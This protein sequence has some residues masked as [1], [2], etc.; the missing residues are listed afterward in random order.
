MFK[1]IAISLMCLLAICSASLADDDNDEQKKNNV[2]FIYN[3]MDIGGGA[4]ESGHYFT[5]PSGKIYLFPYWAQTPI[6]TPTPKPTPLPTPTPKPTPT[7][8]PT[9]A[10]TKANAFNSCMQCHK[11]TAVKYTFINWVGSLHT[12]SAHKSKACSTC[13]NLL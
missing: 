7:P 12:K 8:I 3:K 11:S 1:K 10:P 13:H 6:P 5:G 4:V 2:R 9:P